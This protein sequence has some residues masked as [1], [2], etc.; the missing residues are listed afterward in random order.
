MMLGS[1]ALKGLAGVGQ[2]PVRG[3]AL[4]HA[5]ATPCTVRRRTGPRHGPGRSRSSRRLRGE[6]PQLGRYAYAVESCVRRVLGI[7]V[8]AARLCVVPAN[9]DEPMLGTVQGGA[10][11][12]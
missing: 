9:A 4:R 7:G 12:G 11:E 3:C 5:A 6:T 1:R 2:G 10:G 8:A